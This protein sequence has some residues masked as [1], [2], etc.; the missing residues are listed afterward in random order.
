MLTGVLQFIFGLL[1]AGK[2]I[3][4]IPHPVVL[5]FVRCQHQARGGAFR[6]RFHGLAEGAHVES[7]VVVLS[8]LLPRQGPAT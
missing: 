6:A 2:F 5:G 7:D 3:T 4:F 1:Q 8:K